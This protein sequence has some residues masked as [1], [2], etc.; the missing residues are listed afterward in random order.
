MRRRKIKRITR[1]KIRK[2]S[3][4][5]APTVRWIARA[6]SFDIYPHLLIISCLRRNIFFNI[7]S[8]AGQTKL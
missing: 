2:I 7:T 1:K 5:I 8:V 6:K 4:V 3:S